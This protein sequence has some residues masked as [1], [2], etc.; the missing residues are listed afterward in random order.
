M[1]IELEEKT[2]EYYIVAVEQ[3]DYEWTYQTRDGAIALDPWVTIDAWCEQ[4]FG[5]QGVWGAPPTTWKRM[6][7]KYF[8]QNER[9]RAWFAL[10][11]SR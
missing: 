3:A 11:W 9:D 4:T 10:R 5:E 6:G 2:T 8:F 7:P 1:K